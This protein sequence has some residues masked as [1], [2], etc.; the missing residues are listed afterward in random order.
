MSTIVSAQATKFTEYDSQNTPLATFGVAP[1]QGSV[2]ICILFINVYPGDVTPAM[3]GTGWVQIATAVSAGHCRITAFYKI[4]GINEPTAVQAQLGANRP[5][6]I[7][8]LNYTGNDPS[9]IDVSATNSGAGTICDSGTVNTSVAVAER[10]VAAWVCVRPYAMTGPTN[11]YTEITSGSHNTGSGNTSYGY[12]SA[13]KDMPSPSTGPAHSTV[14]KTIT[15]QWAGL[16]FAIR[17]VAPITYIKTGQITVDST[18]VS[19]GKFRSL[20]KTGSVISQ[21]AVLGG[22]S[23]IRAKSGA[24]ISSGVLSAFRPGLYGRTGVIKV[25]SIILSGGEIHFR[26]AT[27]QRITTDLVHGA[28]SA[29]VAT[30]GTAPFQGTYTEFTP[31]QTDPHTAS[32]YVRAS[33]QIRLRITTAAG[34]TISI[35]DVIDPTNNWMRV[36]LTPN[37]P[38]VQ[39]TK[40]RFYIET[41]VAVATA[42]L[43]DAAQIEVGVVASPF[44]VG[45]RPAGGGPV[46]D[47]IHEQKPAGLLGQYVVVAGAPG[48]WAT[49]Q[50]LYDNH[51]DYENV[52]DSKQTYKQVYQ[53]PGP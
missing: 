40:Y 22:R 10:H 49:Y 44:V 4:A 18:A 14:T 46:G 1:P 52:L 31:T 32:V 43:I 21:M 20:V 16:V 11:G 5:C 39:G 9:P 25:S 2:M 30:T 36:A 8:I 47:I 12:T 35:S 26:G 29:Q 50:V 51:D 7:Q 37:Q 24:L 48:I 17:S 23:G 19:S 33:E 6:A 53:N 34:A 42:F 27:I 28:A 15:D 45:T 38:L 3:M 13:E 41:A